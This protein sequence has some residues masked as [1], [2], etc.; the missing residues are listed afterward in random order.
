MTCDMMNAPNLID[1][2]TMETGIFQIISYNNSIVT[3]LFGNIGL[4][5]YTC[6]G[7]NQ[8]VSRYCYKLGIELELPTELYTTSDT[9]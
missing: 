7:C 4:W 9:L 3:D 2:S 6:R 5:I 8:K 1:A